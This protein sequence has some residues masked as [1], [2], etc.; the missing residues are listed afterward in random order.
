MEREFDC[1][2]FDGAAL[3][4]FMKPTT[5]ANSKEYGKEAFL[6]FIQRELNKV[7]RVDVV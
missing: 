5:V 2:V 7:N 4:H 6:A 1:K 3:V